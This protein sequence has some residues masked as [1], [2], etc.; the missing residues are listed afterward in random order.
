MLTRCVRQEES[1]E[2]GLRY[3]YK[4]LNGEVLSNVSDDAFYANITIKNNVLELSRVHY[5]TN[6]LR[7]IEKGKI[8]E[9]KRNKDHYYYLIDDAHSDSKVAIRLY[10][11]KH[12]SMRIDAIKC[13][14]RESNNSIRDEDLH[15]TGDIRWK[16]KYRKL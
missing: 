12:S 4:S 13:E 8:L 6:K 11:S 5:T 15:V 7:G 3:I 16:G 1:N 9:S 14:Y 2:T 10:L